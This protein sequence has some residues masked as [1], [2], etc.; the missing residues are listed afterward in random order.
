MIL[1]LNIQ[2]RDRY[3]GKY[4]KVMIGFILINYVWVRLLLI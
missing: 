3:N 1:N 4:Y 2:G